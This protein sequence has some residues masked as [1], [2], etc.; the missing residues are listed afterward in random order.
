MDKTTQP[1][2]MHSILTSPELWIA[3]AFLIFVELFLK[4]VWPPIAK[5][6][7]KRADDIRDQLEKASRLRAEAEALLEAYRQ[8]SAAKHREAEE[9]VTAAKKDA[10]ELRARAEAELKQNLERR[11]QQA[12]EKI[13][14]A[15]IEAT[16]AIRLQMI[17]IA[18]A[19]VT[20]IIQQELGGASSEDPAIVHAIRAIE[21]QIH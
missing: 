2:E 17:D 9:I 21:Q 1:E 8:E 19:A 16:A 7:D 18:S 15:E 5:M 4:F 12:L 13:A 10:D 3:V 14:R 6:L 11:S 20:Q